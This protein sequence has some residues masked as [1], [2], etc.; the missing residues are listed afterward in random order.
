MGLSIGMESSSDVLPREAKGF[1]GM[2]ELRMTP[3]NKGIGVFATQFIPANQQLYEYVGKTYNKEEA[4]ALLDSMSSHEEREF[5]LVHIYGLNGKFALCLNDGLMINHSYDP[6]IG[7]LPGWDESTEIDHA[8]ALRDIQKGEELT[9]D[10]RT[11]IDP[12][13]FLEVCKKYGVTVDRS[14][15]V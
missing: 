7:R 13:Y 2:A 9:Q 15:C 8:Y 4:I 12:P 10:Y 14:F 11:F 6:T 5:W 3:D 1:L